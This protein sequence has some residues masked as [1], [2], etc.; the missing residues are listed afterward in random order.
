[1][2]DEDTHG[3]HNISFAAVWRRSS[4][5]IC[6]ACS[7]F[8]LT[9]LAARPPAARASAA[10]VLADCQRNGKLSA[11]Y[12]IADL[13][14]ALAN[15]PVDV[16]QYTNCYD[17]IQRQLL[18]QIQSSSGSGGSGG[19]GG[20]FLPTWLIVVLVLLALAAATF[21]A[22]EIRRRRGAP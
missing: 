9:T 12:S 15:M 14:G 4:V 22:I 10:A 13:R 16:K 6:L 21:A 5:L 2:E 8:V 18:A 3:V 19:S 11:Q 20:S 7:V 1:V 17:V